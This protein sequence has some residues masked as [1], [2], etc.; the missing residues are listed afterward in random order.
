MNKK[1]QEFEKELLKNI[2][3]GNG[4]FYQ[5]MMLSQEYDVSPEKIKKIIDKQLINNRIIWTGTKYTF[6]EDLK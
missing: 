3:N 4:T 5:I 1:Y 6:I 2:K